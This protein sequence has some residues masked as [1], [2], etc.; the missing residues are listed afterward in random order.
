MFDAKVIET[1]Q[2]DK[3]IRIDVN[4]NGLAIFNL[5]VSADEDVGLGPAGPY[6]G[7][8]HFGLRVNNLDDTAAELKR[9]GCEFAI[10]PRTVRPGLRIAYVRGPENVRIELVERA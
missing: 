1:V 6:L 3:S 9:R 10:E 2:P 7:L 5:R 8:D 4:L